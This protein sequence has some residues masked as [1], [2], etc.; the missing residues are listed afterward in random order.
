MSGVADDVVI[1]G[2]ELQHQHDEVMPMGVLCRVDVEGDGHQAPNV[3]DAYGV[4][5][6][7]GDGAGLHW[8]VDGSEVRRQWYCRRRTG[9]RLWEDDTTEC[10]KNRRKGGPKKDGS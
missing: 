8:V 9:W 7:A 6:K 5:V 2:E 3:V 1:K 4:G 10:S